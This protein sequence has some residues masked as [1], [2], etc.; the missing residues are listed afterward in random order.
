M[1]KWIQ[2]IVDQGDLNG[3]L[4]MGYCYTCGAGIP[5]DEAQVTKWWRKAVRRGQ[6][7]VE[8]N[9]GEAYITGFGEVKENKENTIKWIK[10]SAEHG[11]KPAQETLS[12]IKNGGLKPQKNTFVPNSPFVV[13]D[14]HLFLGT[15][16]SR[17]K[18]DR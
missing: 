11:H 12:K 10:S 17:T 7:S 5:M 16:V 8:F 1:V 4:P 9:L 15:T 3:L 13:G 14:D 2:I 6:S 18:T